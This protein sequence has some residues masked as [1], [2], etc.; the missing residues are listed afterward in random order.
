MSL[1]WRRDYL[2]LA[3]LEQ[4]S[5]THHQVVAVLGPPVRLR[6]LGLD[7]SVYV[8][9]TSNE[10][11]RAVLYELSHIVLVNDGIDVFQ[12]GIQLGDAG[13]VE[14]PNAPSVGTLID[15]RELVVVR[16]AQ[17]P[18]HHRNL[19]ASQAAESTPPYQVVHVVVDAL[20]VRTNARLDGFGGSRGG[21]PDLGGLGDFG[22]SSGGSSGAALDRQM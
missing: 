3:E 17:S 16:V 21:M 6:P 8:A 14:G 7:D 18:R 5:G 22:D 20:V 10:D 15:I 4:L 12:L 19:F 13:S 2:A 9:A 11:G 1:D